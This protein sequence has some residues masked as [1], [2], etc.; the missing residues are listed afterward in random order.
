MNAGKRTKL[1]VVLLF[2]LVLPLAVGCGRKGPAD[3]PPPRFKG[4]LP[5]VDLSAFDGKLDLVAIEFGEG[6]HEVLIRATATQDLGTAPVMATA[7]MQDA[8]GTSL[9]EKFASLVLDP[10]PKGPEYPPIPAGSKVVITVGVSA[11]TQNTRK[12]I[13]TPGG[14]PPAGPAPPPPPAQPESGPAP[15]AQP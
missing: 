11:A 7:D 5:E 15:P 9:G 4:D 3:I 6:R 14:S 12:I 1:A 2:S 10:M 8:Q 13:L